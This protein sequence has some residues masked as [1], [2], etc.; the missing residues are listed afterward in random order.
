M[1]PKLK[2]EISK[3]KP[4]GSRVQFVLDSHSWAWDVADRP[5]YIPSEKTDFP[6]ALYLVGL[7]YTAIVFVSS[8]VHIC[9]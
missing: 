4:K 2:R 9:L 1:T 7:V 6:F 8:Y 5:S 3:T